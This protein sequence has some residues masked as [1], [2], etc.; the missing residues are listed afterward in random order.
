MKLVLV[1]VFAVSSLSVLTSLFTIYPP[2]YPLFLFLLQKE[3]VVVLDESSDGE[4]ERLE[5][6]GPLKSEY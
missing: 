6:G 5:D 1:I 4:R 3:C 2:S